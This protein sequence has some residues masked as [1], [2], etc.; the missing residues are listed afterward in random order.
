MRYNIAVA[1]T[2]YVDLSLAQ[3]NSVTAVDVIPEKVEMINRH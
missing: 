2:G 1:D 3:H